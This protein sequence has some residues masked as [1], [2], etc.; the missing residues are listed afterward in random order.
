[1]DKLIE[2]KNILA[3]PPDRIDKISVKDY[4]EIRE[5]I[6]KIIDRE[7]GLD[8]S[9]GQEVIKEIVAY[10]KRNKLP[11]EQSA[12]STSP[13]SGG[14]V[15]CLKPIYSKKSRNTISTRSI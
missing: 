4:A 7:D 2:I 6:L 1:M 5:E 15:R 3:Q 14:F 9:T 11:K 8:G 12:F 10:R 13:N